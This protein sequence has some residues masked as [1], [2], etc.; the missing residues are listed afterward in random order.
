[1]VWDGIGVGF[2]QCEEVLDEGWKTMGQGV[3]RGI[4]NG[5]GSALNW[6]EEKSIV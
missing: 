5:V 2:I 3:T 1:V 4:Y 6:R